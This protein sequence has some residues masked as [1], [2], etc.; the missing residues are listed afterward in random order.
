MGEGSANAS[1][2]NMRVGICPAAF[3]VPLS[4]PTGEGTGEGLRWLK[5]ESRRY[6]GALTLALSHRMGEGSANAS[7][8]NM[9]IGICP[10]AFIVP[11]SRPTGEGTGEGL[12]GS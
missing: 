8:E 12:F 4:R 10:A 7:F 1:F 5:D 11:L 9:R 6:E 2:E 3:I